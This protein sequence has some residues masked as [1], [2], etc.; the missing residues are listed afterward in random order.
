MQQSSR[1]TE[2]LRIAE[3]HRDG[4][5]AANRFLVIRYLANGLDRSRFC[6]VVSK[7]I[8]NAVARNKV[9]RRLREAL[10]SS[11][12][13]P[14]WDAVFIARSY[15]RSASYHDLKQAADNLLRRSA[16]IQRGDSESSPPAVGSRL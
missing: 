3:I 12:V 2:S 5:S 11:S 14:G 15:V 7:R 9:K 16:L 4:L 13:K 8:G 6:F 1:L 10:R